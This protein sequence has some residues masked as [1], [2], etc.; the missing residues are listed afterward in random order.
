MPAAGS[1]MGAFTSESAICAETRSATGHLRDF[2]DPRRRECSLPQGGRGGPAPV[3]PD[4]LMDTGAV[5]LST[6]RHVVGAPDAPGAALTGLVIAT[7][8]H[9]RADGPVGRGR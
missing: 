1:S 3:G 4:R 9:A 5:C 7:H 2:A 8:L 6:Q